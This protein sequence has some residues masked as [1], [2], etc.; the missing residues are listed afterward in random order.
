MRNLHIVS[1][2]HW[3]R[4]WYRT[5]QDFRLR[6]VELVD[7]LLD[8]LDRDPRFRCFMLDGQTVVLDDYLQLRP[9]NEERI[10]RYIRRGRLLIGPW[11]ILPDE[12]LVSP[13]ATIRNL[14]EG[15]RT[16]S[17]FGPRMPVGYIPDPFGHI[18]QMPQILR[19]F[20]ITS[21]CLWRGLD[22]Q[23]AELWWQSPDGSR[24][25]LAYLR[26]S[27]SNGAGLPV[28]DLPAFTLAVSAA[29]DSLAAHSAFPHQL[30]MLGT[31]HMPPPPETSRAVAYANRRLRG[32]LLVH[33][34]LP[35][36]LAAIQAGLSKRKASLPA[37]EGELRACRRMHL[38]PGVL[39]ARMWIKQRNRACETLLEKWVEPFTVFAA[40]TTADRRPSTAVGSPSSVVQRPS[41]VVRQAWRLLM[42][43]HPHDSIC[44]CSIDQVHDEMKVRFDQVDQIGEEI[45]RRSLAALAGQIEAR[46]PTGEAIAAIVV[47]NPGSSSRTDRVTAQVELPPGAAAFELTDEAGRVIP[48]ESAGLAGRDLIRVSMGGRELASAFGSISEGRAA[49]QAIQA[50]QVRREG[51]EVF[52][53]AVLSEGG[54]PDLAAWSAA[55]GQIDG[56]LADRSITHY[57]V[58][59]RS[60]GA[61]RLLFTAP[62]VPGLGW[63]TFH[64]RR[65]SGEAAAP[66]IGPLARLLFPL[67]RLPI[68]RKLSAL[69]R[70][71]GRP[72][73]IENEFLEVTLGRDGTASL[74][75]KRDGR[76]CGGLNRFVNGGDCGDEYN[77]C[78]PVR[79]RSVTARP[80]RVSVTRG[81]VE[82]T[83][84]VELMLKAPAGL[85]P[86]RGSRS[87]E[88][89]R[90]PIVTRLTLTRGVPR[91]DIQ[92]KIENRARDHRLRVHFPAPF[93][94]ASAHHDGHFEV[95]ERPVGM[96]ECDASWIE[97]PRPEVPQRAFTSVSDG[98]A[99]LTVAN[100]G[101][102]EVEVL[103]NASGNA[104]IALTLLRCVGWLSRDD[105][106]A[107]KGH[108]GPFME[109]PGAQMAGEWT[110]EYAVVPGVGG[111]TN[112]YLH[113]Y[114]FES[115]LRAVSGS[116]HGGSLPCSGA[117][118]KVGP[119]DFV[120]SAVK[121]AADGRGWIVRGCNMSDR[122][123]VVK[124]E[125]W[126]RFGKAALVNLAEEKGKALRPGRDGSVVLPAGR[127]QIV[128][129]KFE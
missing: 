29:G 116:L 1:H 51:A 42:E 11:H 28:G 124:I 67:V 71:A 34:S 32:S 94:A 9:E 89:V 83:L 84:T 76:R 43:N 108:A 105:F 17:R 35:Q 65:R 75:D 115:P 102:P 55:R 24:V 117:F 118:L 58:Q 23:P 104:E 129:V 36:Y 39:S 96:P 40:L 99:G 10:R 46:P 45:V 70:Q 57:H 13:E 68:V 82:Q 86:D 101:L 69:P 122:D 114:A 26:D 37:V 107:R 64:V 21:A 112:G 79:D 22:E 109:T 78:P 4:E 56:F 103:K 27:Y 12:F 87:R 15:M 100:R 19:G 121:A 7:G 77:F 16:C 119:T 53:E 62:N 110:F 31:D 93:P 63:R 38:L 106:P 97:Q 113:A 66:R 3:D 88:T 85:A 44:G 128:S 52:I 81:P 61:A 14:L 92:T 126:Q 73:R 80:R 54:E 91:L 47:F 127:K 98:K 5:Y 74:L 30:I 123:I 8:I 48:H 18:G 59:A 60:A 120:V 2:T 41:S 6:L 50:V 90:I 25:L 95:V 20:G 49:G 125:P 111:W 72:W 33:S